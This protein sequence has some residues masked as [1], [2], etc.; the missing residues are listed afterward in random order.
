MLL[1]ATGFEFNKDQ[2]MELNINKLKIKVMPE[3]LMVLLV[4]MMI[5][6]QR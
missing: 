3:Q 5:V 6:T 2:H 4:M 1:I